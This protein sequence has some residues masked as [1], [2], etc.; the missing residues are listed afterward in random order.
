MM[1]SMVE[2]SIQRVGENVASE[3]CDV[4]RDCVCDSTVVS[5]IDR[6]VRSKS[7]E[8]PTRDMRPRMLAP[9][10]LSSGMSRSLQF[11]RAHQN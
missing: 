9:R 6:G 5:D 7:P 3:T 2:V 1:A 11:S 10:V 4:T 8:F